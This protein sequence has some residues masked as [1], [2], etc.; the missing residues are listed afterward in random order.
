[1]QQTLEE[2]YDYGSVMH[3]SQGAFSK[4]GRATIAPKNFFGGIIMGQRIGFSP[5][6]LRKINKLYNC[7]D[8]L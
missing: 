6:D 1:M 4:N 8:Y 7:V 5:T 2:E 3:Y